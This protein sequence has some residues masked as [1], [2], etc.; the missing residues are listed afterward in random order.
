MHTSTVIWAQQVFAKCMAAASASPLSGYISWGWVVLNLPFKVRMSLNAQ[1]SSNVSL[2]ADFPWATV[3]MI[4]DSLEGLPAWRVR[5]C[6]LREETFPALV[7][8]LHSSF[9]SV[10][11][12]G[13][14]WSA[15]YFTALRKQLIWAKASSSSSYNFYLNEYIEQN[16]V[17]LIMPLSQTLPQPPYNFP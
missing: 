8:S 9:T 11:S 17:W 10:L 16:A 12:S 13:P 2:S 14:M 15:A 7:G 6:C 5:K 1:H 3:M 4:R